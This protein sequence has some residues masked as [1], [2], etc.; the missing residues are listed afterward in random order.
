MLELLASIGVVG[1]VILIVGFVTLFWLAK[2]ID[3]ISD[4]EGKDDD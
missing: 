2:L 1:I 4:Y 3:G